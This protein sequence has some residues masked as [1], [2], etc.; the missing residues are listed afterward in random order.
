M[1]KHIKKIIYKAY[2]I[3]LMIFTIWYGYF[4]YPLIFGFEGKEAAGLSLRK[5]VPDGTKEEQ[6][7][8]RMKAEKLK[9]RKKTDLGYRTID[10]PYIKGHFHHIGFTIKQDKTSICVRCHGNSPHVESKEI[11][12]FLNMHSFYL[13]CETCHSIPEDGEP[14]WEFSW[15]NKSTGKP[16]ENPTVMSD[17]EDSYKSSKEKNGYPVY[18]DYGAKIAPV[19]NV[20]GKLALLHDEEDMAMVERYIVERD[21]LDPEQKTLRTNIIHR[22]KS[23]RTVECRS[24]H[25]EQAPYIPFSKLGYP[26]TRLRELFNNPVVGMLQKYKEFYIPSSLSPA[27]LKN[28]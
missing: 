12:A 8:E 16:S 3:A 6:I 2:V 5:A 27:F 20:F 18:G 14:P 23:V 19:I 4:M 25:Q 22:K 24:C 11:R 9:E 21:N 26:P 28:E 10:Q 13:A 1:V 15:Y 17:I 7:F